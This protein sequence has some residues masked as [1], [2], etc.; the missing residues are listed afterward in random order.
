MPCILYPSENLI[1][2]CLLDSADQQDK[3]KVQHGG[4]GNAFSLA[5]NKYELN[6][7]RTKE[8][9]EIEKHMKSSEETFSKIIKKQNAEHIKK[10]KDFGTKHEE[11]NGK[12]MTGKNQCR[13]VRKYC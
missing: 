12:H 13:A 5:N 8:P 7:V 9:K 2:L 11:A 1:I 3:I 4:S 6:Y 10:N